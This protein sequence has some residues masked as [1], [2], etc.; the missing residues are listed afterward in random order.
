MN[1]QIREGN[2]GDLEQIQKLSQLLFIKEQKEYDNYYDINWPFS[3]TGVNSFTKQF[4]DSDKKVFVAEIDSEIVGYLAASLRIDD[5]YRSIKNE[6]L[7]IA[8]L[9]DMMVLEEY[10]SQGIGA[11]LVDEFK[12]WAKINNADRIMVLASSPN[13]RGIEFYKK[14]GFEIFEVGLKKDL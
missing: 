2:L 8:E 5:E 6:I 12:K 11:L 14:Q 4:S 13:A 3:E 9:N 10:R 7:R 1:I